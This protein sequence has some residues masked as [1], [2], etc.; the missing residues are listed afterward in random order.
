M[1]AGLKQNFTRFSGFTQ[2]ALEYLV[3][4]G[5]PV[6]PHVQQEVWKE[7][8]GRY[9]NEGRTFDLYR[10]LKS[11]PAYFAYTIGWELRNP[12]VSIP[13]E[14]AESFVTD[15]VDFMAY[16]DKAVLTKKL[17]FE[18]QIH[19]LE[20]IQD[21]LDRV[22]DAKIKDNNVRQQINLFIDRINKA[23]ED[24]REQT[25]ILLEAAQQTQGEELQLAVIER[26]NELMQ[27][28]LQHLSIPL[29]KVKKSALE[30]MFNNFDSYYE[31]DQ[32][33]ILHVA[34]RKW[35][36]D[37]PSRFAHRAFV[38]NLEQKVPQANMIRLALDGLREPRFD[39]N[40][41]VPGGTVNDV[42]V[43]LDKWYAS[44]HGATETGREGFG[45]AVGI[46]LA[47]NSNMQKV[48]E[49][50]RFHYEWLVSQVKEN[51]G[52]ARWCKGKTISEALIP[53]EPS[54]LGKWSF[55]SSFRHPTNA[56]YDKALKAWVVEEPQGMLNPN[57][58]LTRL[59]WLNER[60]HDRDIGILEFD[61][62]FATD[63]MASH[64]TA[65]EIAGHVRAE[66][67]EC[68]QAFSFL[69][70]DNALSVEMAK[71]RPHPHGDYFNGLMRDVITARFYRGLT[72]DEV[73]V[74]YC[75][76]SFKKQLHKITSFMMRS[77]QHRF[78]DTKAYYNEYLA[79]ALQFFNFSKDEDAV[80]FFTVEW[81][82]DLTDDALSALV[83]K[84]ERER[85]HEYRLI[86]AAYTGVGEGETHEEF[87]WDEEFADLSAM[88][89]WSL[90]QQGVNVTGRTVTHEGYKRNSGGREEYLT[91]ERAQNEF[92]VRFFK[93][94]YAKEQ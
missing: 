55:G 12:E 74:L 32:Q 68:R 15:I 92:V 2:K 77:T 29:S 59:Y 67:D 87:V 53:I 35:P 63:F 48:K 34:M 57:S 76:D 4:A 11:T 56:H 6:N 52:L 81:G 33:N 10:L 84:L 23:R 43:W 70:I 73:K 3:K 21:M 39:P 89:K 13:V 91:P 82:L 45:I 26:K 54:W 30:D 60:L 27:Q 58:T 83:E 20:G 38:T 19:E 49:Y 51:V 31:E 1:V 24:A 42:V 78:H 61:G 64:S 66:I 28:H 36:N 94:N 37:I 69:Q 22:R 25:R 65:E 88:E 75:N 90:L 85:P 62:S 40:V 44:L 93:F 80:K 46:R 14:H 50:S 72:T 71:S 79:E 7:L 47:R 5:T 8:F 17:E 86:K 9:F 16:V 18:W 41:L